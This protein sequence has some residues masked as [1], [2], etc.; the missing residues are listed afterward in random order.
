MGEKIELSVLG[1]CCAGGSKNDWKEGVEVMRGEGEEEE[2]EEEEE[3]VLV[4]LACL[5]VVK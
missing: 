1:F 3:V 4:V 2:E 5:S